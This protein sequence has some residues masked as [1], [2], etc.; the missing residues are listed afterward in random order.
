MA[1]SSRGPFQPRNQTHSSPTASSLSLGHQGSPQ[2]TER[3]SKHNYRHISAPVLANLKL[4]FSRNGRPK[5]RPFWLPLWVWNLRYT[6]GNE[7]DCSV[8]GDSQR[9]LLRKSPSIKKIGYNPNTEASV[10]ISGCHGDNIAGT[11]CHHAFQGMLS[12]P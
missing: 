7:M 12:H 1:I 5:S 9:K 3:S 8:P 4:V 11:K 2:D 6:G 10:P